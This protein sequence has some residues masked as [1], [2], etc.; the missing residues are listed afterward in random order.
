M[1]DQARQEIERFLQNGD[2]IAAVRHLKDAY[3]FSLAQSKTLVDALEGK[4]DSAAVRSHLKAGKGTLDQAATAHV[5]ALIQEG[6]KIDA[7]RFVK[8]TLGIRLK[9]ARQLVEQVGYT[10]RPDRTL[11]SSRASVRTVMALVFGGIGLIFLCV[12]GVIFYYQNR[13]V[14]SSDRVA[15][16]V[17]R[18]QT[19]N[20]GAASPVIAYEWNGQEWLH[21]STMYTSPPAYTVDEEV[22]IYVNRRD[23]GDI[24]IDTF[25]DRWLLITIF[26][27]MGFVFTAIPVLIIA[28]TRRH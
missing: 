26:G 1:T 18:L 17:I 4:A 5:S 14:E 10:T 27:V 19:R 25:S 23:P 8:D 13:S 7:I 9:D 22:P 16:T 20:D 3:G 6:R 2:K 28:F 21:A 11:G 12:A 24:T 15:G